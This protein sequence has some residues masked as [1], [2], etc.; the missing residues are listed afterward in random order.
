M[1]AQMEARGNT[2]MG[3]GVL[4]TNVYWLQ[5]IKI[6]VEAMAENKFIEKLMDGLILEKNRISML[7]YSRIRSEIDRFYAKYLGVSDNLMKLLYKFITRSIKNR[8]Q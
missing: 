1:W 4:D 8:L 5:E 7:K 6:P 3:F 2:N